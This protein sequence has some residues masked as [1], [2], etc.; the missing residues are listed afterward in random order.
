MKVTIENNNTVIRRE[1]D[2]EWVKGE[3]AMGNYVKAEYNS[4]EDKTERCVIHYYTDNSYKGMHPY[5]VR[6]H[7]DDD[8]FNEGIFTDTLT[9]LPPLPKYPKPEDAP[10][11]YRYM[12]EGIIPVL[13]HA[14]NGKS[15][16]FFTWKVGNDLDC[17]GMEGVDHLLLDHATHNG[18]RVEVALEKENE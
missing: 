13:H 4:F 9:I 6:H 12:A 17:Y 8:G 5:K 15:L 7:G 3:L 10:L 14:R 16:S 1:F 11:L 2:A 18:E